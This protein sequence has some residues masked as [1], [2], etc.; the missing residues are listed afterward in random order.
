MGGRSAHRG[1]RGAGRDPGEVFV[2]V[3]L[4]VCFDALRRL[5]VI[6]LPVI[7]FVLTFG[8]CPPLL[9]IWEALL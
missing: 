7:I 2:V 6:P 1:S 5:H 4:S 9:V 3:H 8:T